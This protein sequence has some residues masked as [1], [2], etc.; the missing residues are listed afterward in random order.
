MISMFTRFYDQT[1]NKID[2]YLEKIKDTKGLVKTEKTKLT[3]SCNPTTPEGKHI[4]VN[5]Y[6]D[7][8]ENLESFRNN[9]SN[10]ELYVKY[11]TGE[12]IRYPKTFEL[13]EP[14]DIAFGVD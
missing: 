8:I 13:R 3:K 1:E 12:K 4:Q 11:S 10:Q 14:T 5:L 2:E 9:K 6:F 7:T